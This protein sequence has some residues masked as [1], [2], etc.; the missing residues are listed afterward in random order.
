MGK[1]SCSAG[2]CVNNMNGL[3]SANKINVVGTNVNT[4]IGTQCETF[5]EKGFVNAFKNLSN[6]NLPGEIRQIFNNGS[7]EMSPEIKCNASNC[8]YNVNRVCNANDIIIYGPGA[9]TSEETQ[10]ETFRGK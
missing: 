9:G 4:S 5:S 8:V 1:L 7:V 10:C 3:C 6:M 2:N